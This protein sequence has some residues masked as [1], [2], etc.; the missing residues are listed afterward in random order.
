MSQSS[1]TRVI[2]IRHGQSTYNAQKR[3]QGSSDASW[4]TELGQQQAYQVQ[5]ILSQTS[6]DAAYVSPLKRTLETAQCILEGLQPIP[7]F[8]RD[9]LR[10]IDLPHWEGLAFK[11]VQSEFAADYQHW[12]TSPQS[13]QITGNVQRLSM[14]DRDS[15]PLPSDLGHNRD[16]NLHQINSES[17]SILTSTD[18]ID[19]VRSVFPVQDLY[20]RAHQ[21]WK[22]LL[23][24]QI[25][26]TILIVSH[27]G[28]IRALASSA[29]GIPIE[30]FHYLQQSNAGITTLEFDSSLQA[31]L[32]GM[33]QTHHL[34][35]ILPKPK[36]GKQ[37][38]RLILLPSDQLQPLM[39]HRLA[40]QFRSIPISF[41]V[42]SSKSANQS[43]HQ[44]LQHHPQ[45]VPLEVTQD[46]L[47]LQW[48]H[49]LV[50][51]R[52]RLLQHPAKT[53]TNALIV[54]PMKTLQRLVANILD[55]PNMDSITIEPDHFT[56]IFYPA[57]FQHPVLQS[58]NIPIASPIVNPVVPAMT[59]ELAIAG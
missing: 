32:T 37:G 27:G 33:N 50:S 2:L 42:S 15:I 49:L 14:F 43:A 36:H 24:K 12:I 22:M 59:T 13:F 10:E 55:L 40:Q 41:S 8:V 25:G 51:Q 5:Q 53:P 56:S 35:E 11:Q 18:E 4:L 44:I 9:H 28:T 7:L 17:G 26:K 1:T 19:A 47:L 38:I 34:G 54:A 46:D 58:L 52:D 31:R 39:T 20:Q 57:Q 45:A 6:I 3:Y 23:P 48:Q 29:I 21:F 16:R 30:Q